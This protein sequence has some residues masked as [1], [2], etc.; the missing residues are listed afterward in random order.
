MRR[1]LDRARILLFSFEF[2]VGLLALAG[3]FL[4]PDI[5]RVIGEHLAKIPDSNE[6]FYGVYGI[7]V[8][9]LVP[10]WTMAQKILNP[11]G[12]R[13]E[14]FLAWPDY[15]QLKDRVVFGLAVVFTAIIALFVIF[16]FEASLSNAIRGLVFA[17]SV[18]ESLMVL[19]SF[20]LAQLT[21]QHLLR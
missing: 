10:C 16:L 12:S 2:L 15:Q 1:L 18:A 6:M 14:K 20:A 8:A 19:A 7:P 13:R 21:I 9:I 4:M 11:Q 5:F 17:L 3:W